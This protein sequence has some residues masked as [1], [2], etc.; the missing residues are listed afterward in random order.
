MTTDNQRILQYSLYGLGLVLW[1]VLWRTFGSV[2]NMVDEFYYP[3]KMV[4][5]PLVG[6]L[7]NLVPILTLAVAMGVAE[8]LRRHMKANKFGI[9]VVSELRRVSWP[10]S[11]DVRGTTLVVL[12]VTLVVSL[13]L[14]MFDKIFDGLIG[15]L[16]KLA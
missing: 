1:Y 14:F 10:A 2:L 5:V 15:L 16:F 6:S 11:K 13:I 9:E 7:M 4:H 12:G 3:V 8:Y